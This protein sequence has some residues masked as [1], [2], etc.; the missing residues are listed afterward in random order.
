MKRKKDT[1]LRWKNEL[2]RHRAEEIERE[3][4]RERDRER[5]NF[6]RLLLKCAGCG[7]NVVHLEIIGW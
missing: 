6:V 1:L 5:G 3:R 7:V 2:D 4:E